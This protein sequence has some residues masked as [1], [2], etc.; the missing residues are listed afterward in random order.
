MTDHELHEKNR[1]SWNEAT[2]AHNSHKGDQAT[3]FRNGGSTL[4]PDEVELLGDI[5]GKSLVHL[6]C[7][8]G[9][10]T[11]SIASKLG[12]M[13]TGVDISDEAIRFA[14]QLSQDSGIPAAFI[15]SD[16]FDWFEDNTQLF[17]IG[18]SSYGATIWLSDIQAWGRGIAKALKSGGRFV[19]I[20][21][22]PT[23]GMFEKPNDHWQI[24]YPY[25]QGTH[26]Q[27]DGVGDYVALT[28]SIAEGEFED[29]VQDFQNPHDSHEFAWGIADIVMALV[30]AGLTLNLLKEYP[31][32]NGFKRFE[33]MQELNGRRFAMPAHYPQQF[34]LMFGIVVTKP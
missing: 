8:A 23:F 20:D 17:D 9:Q 30:D 6:Q 22:H 3:F 32:A 31:Y 33:D 29:G 5:L 16:V 19:Y 21:F 34:P 28:G 1:L 18:F 7:N 10:D 4:F 24:T 26:L 27:F 15:R 2:K 14:S 25:M 13:V 11:L 12:A